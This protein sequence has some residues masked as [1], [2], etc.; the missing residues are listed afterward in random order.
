[1]GHTASVGWTIALQTGSYE[2][3]LERFNQVTSRDPGGW[4]GWLGA[5]LA[6]SA[7]GHRSLARHDFEMAG[8]IKPR[9]R[10]IGEALAR[11]DTT[12]PLSPV[13][14]LQMLVVVM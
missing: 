14:A 2:T 13:A 12:N 9:D 7:L 8:A 5:G 10:L 6:A 11:V 4:Y 1:M 3:A